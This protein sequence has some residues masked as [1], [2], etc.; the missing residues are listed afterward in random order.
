MAYNK[1]KVA[2]K[3][4]RATKKIT[5][6]GKIQ[7]A[8]QGPG[9]RAGAARTSAARKLKAAS[10]KINK[11]TGTKSG[12]KGKER[13]NPIKADNQKYFGKKSAK[14]MKLVG[15]VQSLSGSKKRKAKRTKHLT[16]RI[17]RVVNRVT[18]KINKKL[19]K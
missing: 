10:R 11:A 9:K 8:N 19:K 4:K 3:I 15:K 5:K 14:S 18:K 1:K 12:L 16:K 6:A 7:R 13:R 17:N 2:R